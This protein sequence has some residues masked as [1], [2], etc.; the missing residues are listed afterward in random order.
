MRGSMPGSWPGRLRIGRTLRR[1]VESWGSLTHLRFAQDTADAD[2]KAAMEYHDALAPT[3]TNHEIAFKRR[4]LGHADRA[5]VAAITGA[6]ALRL[7]ETDITTFT[8]EIEADLQAEAK[9]QSRYTE[10]L[11]SAKIE[12]EGADRQ[13][14]GPRPLPAKPGPRCAPPRRGRALGVF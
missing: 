13:P 10:L 5:G 11:A 6:H 3:A 4:L 12:I 1:E 14:L 7:W 9:L 2:A 8:P